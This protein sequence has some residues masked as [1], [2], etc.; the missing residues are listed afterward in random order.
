MAIYSFC[1]NPNDFVNYNKQKPIVNALKQ[2]A[3]KILW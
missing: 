2:F 3:F 1:K